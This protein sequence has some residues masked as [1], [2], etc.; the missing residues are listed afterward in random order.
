MK[1]LLLSI[2]FAFITIATLSAQST[3]TYEEPGI[4]SLMKKYKAQNDTKTHVRGFRIQVS[5][6][7]DR[8]K[9][10]EVEVYL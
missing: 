10:N 9:I 7:T 3:I 1:S 8:A 4:T 6:T 5:S 2:S